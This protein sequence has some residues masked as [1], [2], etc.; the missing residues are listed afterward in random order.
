MLSNWSK[1]T[2][3]F[4]LHKIFYNTLEKENTQKEE[5][6]VKKSRRKDLDQT[7]HLPVLFSDSKLLTWRTIALNGY[8][9]SCASFNF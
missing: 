9:T 4:K 3:Y 1:K 5:K 7:W 2:S 8:R 6:T